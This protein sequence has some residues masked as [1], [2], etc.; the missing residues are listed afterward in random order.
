LAETT[1]REKILVNWS[2]LSQLLSTSCCYTSTGH[3]I[4][5]Y[6]GAQTSTEGM[7]L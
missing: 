6:L 3:P 7:P 2:E 5:P 4:Y 1:F